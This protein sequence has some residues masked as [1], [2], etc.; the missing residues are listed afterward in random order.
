MNKVEGMR[1]K[2]TSEFL[3]SI[4]VALIRKALNYYLKYHDEESDTVNKELKNWEESVESS[5]F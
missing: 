4:N 1:L 3:A 2:T 5:K